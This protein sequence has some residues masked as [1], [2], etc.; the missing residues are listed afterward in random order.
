MTKK[1]I[2]LILQRLNKQVD[3]RARYQDARSIITG[4][5][6]LLDILIVVGMIWFS[7]IYIRKYFGDVTAITVREVIFY[8]FVLLTWIILLQFANLPRIIPRT[9]KQLHILFSFLRIG[10]VGLSVITLVKTILFIQDINI[11]QLFIFSFASILIL[12]IVRDFA[13]VIF[14][15]YRSKGVNLHY[16]IVYADHFSDEVLESLFSRK[17]WG[18]KVL[19]VLTDSKLIKAKFR[20]RVKIISPKIDVKVLLKNFVIDEVIYCKKN[21][22]EEQVSSLLRTCNEIG[23]L[24]RLQSSFSPL[25][26]TPYLQLPH[27]VPDLIYSNS[28][29]S[30]LALIVKNLSDYYIS[31][32]LLVFLSPLMI[33]ISLLIMID[34]GRPIFFKQVRV[35]LRGRKFNLFKFRTMVRNAE[36]MRKNLEILNEM[37]GPVFKIKRDPRITRIGGFLRKTGLDEMPQLVNVLLGHMSLIGPRPPIPSEV[38]IYEPWQ[39]RRLAVKPGITCTWQVQP[40]RNDIKFEDWMKLDLKYIDNWSLTTDFRLFFRTIKTVLGRTGV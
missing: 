32:L 2:D 34:S 35:G 22:D 1:W 33:F 24:F 21:I 31:A 17:S 20:N 29:A 15:Y 27:P 5:L 7:F 10:F 37:D 25:K 13:F 6:N 11:S 19:I 40:N 30:E 26:A 38:E 36:E 23:V 16:A 8:L 18:I 3:R 39:L 14:K 4:L 9:T 28:Q 12:F